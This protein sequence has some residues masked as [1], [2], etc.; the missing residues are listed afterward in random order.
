[1]NEWIKVTDK[2]PKKFGKYLTCDNY[3]N[4]NL[5]VYREDAQ[6]PF[7]IS[8]DNEDYNMVAYWMPLPNPPIDKQK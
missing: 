8:P 3:R 6:Y 4:I 2:L 7:G 1:M 5:F